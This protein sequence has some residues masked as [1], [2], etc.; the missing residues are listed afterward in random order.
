ML[1]R[2]GV[3]IAIMSADRENPRNLAF[4]AAMASAFGLPHEEALR[5]I[6]FDCQSVVEDLLIS[7]R[8][9]EW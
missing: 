6:T 5:A 8:V 9:R 1:A 2:A 4:H 3:P 7:A